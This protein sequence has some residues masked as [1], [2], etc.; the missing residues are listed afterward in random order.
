MKAL[1]RFIRILVQGLLVI[2]CVSILW[3]LLYRW[4]NPPTT[5]TRMI[6]ASQPVQ[7]KGLGD[8]APIMVLSAIVAEDLRFCD[9]QGFD[10]ESVT[11]AIERSRLGLGLVGA[12]TISQQTARTVFLWQNRSWVRKG[13]ETWF[14]FWIELFWSKDRILEVYLNSVEWGPGIYGIGAAVPHYFG[15]AQSTQRLSGA[16]SAFLMVLLPA[17]KRLSLTLDQTALQRRAAI[18]LLAPTKEA[19]ARAHCLPRNRRDS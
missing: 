5:P 17:P 14:T 8:I 19:L 4:I 1:K 16:Q 7:W 11:A 10:W 9:H 6:T 15:T 18:E 12:S 13:L 2:G 3:V